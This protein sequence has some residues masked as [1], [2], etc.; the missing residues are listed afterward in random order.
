MKKNIIL[1]ALA[2]TL[3]ASCGIYNH[4]ER[5]TSLP[6]EHLY[7]QSIGDSTAQADSTSIASLPWKEVYTETH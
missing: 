5:P 3:L 1:T 4:Y 6:L 7:Q 2:S